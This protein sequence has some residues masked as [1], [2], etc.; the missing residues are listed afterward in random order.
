MW[1]RLA[2]VAERGVD[3]IER[4]QA[5]DGMAH[6]SPV[7][8]HQHAVP[9]LVLCLTGTIQ[10]QG[11]TLL[12]LAAGEALI[13]EPGCWHDHVQHPPQTLSFGMGML[14]GRCDV[15]FF[16]HGQG[17][18]GW[19]PQDPYAG[20]LAGLMEAPTADGRKV[21]LQELLGGV[22]RDQVRYV[23]WP[24]IGVLAMASHLWNHLH[25]PINATD[26]V[27]RFG[28]GGGRNRAFLDFKTFFGRTPK[29]E[30]LMQRLLLA[31]HLLRRGWAIADS[32]KRCGFTDRADLTRA[33]SRRFGRPPSTARG[34]T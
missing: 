7:P 27:A 4:W 13:I 16:G 24:D 11:R 33:Y 34:T 14:A 23:E 17:L 26:L 9:T 28:T 21:I 15:L 29:Q 18:W 3:R 30:L 25:D 8:A 22:V 31:D 12:D 5:E 19:V 10:V 2:R 1:Q 20:L 6:P 32:A